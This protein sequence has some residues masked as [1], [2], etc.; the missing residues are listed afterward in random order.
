MRFSKEV[1]GKL[2]DFTIKFHGSHVPHGPGFPQ[3]SHPGWNE[4]LLRLRGVDMGVSETL[5]KAEDTARQLKSVKRYC[6]HSTTDNVF[7]GSCMIIW[8]RMNAPKLTI[9]LQVS[10]ENLQRYHILIVSLQ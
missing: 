10:K 1:A 6:F 9:L 8:L 4:L 7:V 2:A 5:H 3:D